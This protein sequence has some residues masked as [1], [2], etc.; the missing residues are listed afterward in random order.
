MLTKFDLK[1]LAEMDDGRIAVAFEQAM[2]RAAIDCEDRPADDRP[3]KLCLEL[4]F[5][6]VLDPAG[7]CESVVC[8]A[9]IKDTLPS[10]KSRKYDLGLRK[11]GM[12]VYQPMALDNHSQEPLDF[13]S[14][15]K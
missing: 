2:R 4:E 5:K 3:R 7:Y 11:G 9:Q 6:P 10:R 14:D 12:F 1:S 13:E 8:Q 15:S